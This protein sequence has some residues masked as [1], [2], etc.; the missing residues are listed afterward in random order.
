M[1]KVLKA[2]FLKPFV[3][4]GLLSF[5][6]LNKKFNPKFVKSFYCNLV[7]TPTGFERRFKDKLIR[8]DYNDFSEHFGMKSSDNLVSGAKM[9]DFNKVQF[10]LDISKQVREDKI[11]ACI[12]EN[13]LD[14]EDNRSWM[15]DNV[16][17]EIQ[18]TEGRMTT[19]LKP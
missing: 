19:R 16:K 7:R 6:G 10:V 2:K 4:N 14:D 5:I 17:E 15:K 8:F 13:S 18:A 3:D 1:I 11:M 9:N 12:D